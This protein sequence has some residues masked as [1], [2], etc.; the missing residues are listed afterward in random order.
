MQGGAAA[1]SIPT[2]HGTEGKEGGG[3]VFGRCSSSPAG[4][5]EG[6]EMAEA[7]EEEKDEGELGTDGGEEAEEEAG[8]GGEDEGEHEDKDDSEGEAEDGREEVESIVCKSL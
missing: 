2:G 8:E 4:E 3:E 1:A 6:D 7:G 5:R